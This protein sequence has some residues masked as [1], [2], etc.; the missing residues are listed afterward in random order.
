MSSRMIELHIGGSRWCIRRDLIMSVRDRGEYSIV[1][2]EVAATGTDLVE[3]DESYDQILSLI[4]G[5]DVG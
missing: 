5:D 2:A 1:A 4:N 3:V